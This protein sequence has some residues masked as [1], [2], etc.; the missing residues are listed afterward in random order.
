MFLSIMLYCIQCKFWVCKTV[1][2]AFNR[3]KAAIELRSQ[4]KSLEA[5]RGRNQN[6]ILSKVEFCLSVLITCHKNERLEREIATKVISS[7]FNVVKT[8]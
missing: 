3:T 2:T 4:K 1:N 8:E 7:K 5:V 6:W